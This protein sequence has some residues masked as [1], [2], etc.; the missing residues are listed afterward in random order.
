MYR[1]KQLWPFVKLQFL[2]IEACNSSGHTET[3]VWHPMV[4]LSG[5]T[6]IFC[7]HISQFYS[8]KGFFLIS[9]SKYMKWQN[10]PH[11]PVALASGVKFGTPRSFL[12]KSNIFTDIL[13]LSM[14]KVKF[15][16][17]MCHKP[18]C[19]RILNGGYLT[20][21]LRSVIFAIFQT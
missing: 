14:Q 15:Y 16:C 10:V 2:F 13:D 6:A 17:K 19:S 5:A 21:F 11:P 9:K 8:Q 7:L 4:F 12:S 18:R 1:H 3:K 20:T